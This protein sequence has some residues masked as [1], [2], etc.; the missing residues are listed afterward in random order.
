M[1]QK[2]T[3]LQ[4]YQKLCIIFGDNVAGKTVVH[5]GNMTIIRR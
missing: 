3:T 5:D 2:T 1:Q 4:Q